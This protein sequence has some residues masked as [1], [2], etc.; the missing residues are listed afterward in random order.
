MIALA[1]PGEELDKLN[2]EENIR[3][4]GVFM[5][6]E[7]SPFTDLRSLI[8]LIRVF[9]REQPRM[10]H[11]M[12]PKA[13]LLSMLA[14]KMCG[15][16]VRLHSFTGLLFPTASGVKKKLFATCDKI[17]CGCATHIVA[18]G[19]GVRKDLLDSSITKKRID[20]LGNGNVRGI[21]LDYYQR[22]PEVM[23][24]AAEIR[25]NIGADADTFIFIFVGRLV[26]DKGIDNLVEAFLNLSKE[27]D[28]LRLLL[29]GE[30]EN[31]DRVKPS[32]I[33]AIEESPLI[34]KTGWKEDVR[35]FYAASDLLV[36]PSRREGFPNVVIEAGAMG[37]PSV[38]T[39]INGSNE[40]ISDGVNGRIIPK[41]DLQPLADEMK[42]LSENREAAAA[43][44]KDARRIVSERYERSFVLN[45]LENYYREILK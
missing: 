30:Y 35:P 27:K 22:T 41:D 1:S 10:V 18:E 14:A 4:L 38:V 37:L 45:K 28:N 5:S 26:K 15:V 12:T 39:D 32:T 25:R 9:R 43:L 20:I 11:S 6:R 21:D 40:I 17:I 8:K 13:G 31:G 44:A 33:Q 7:I 36:F 29:V 34:I 24:K 2:R 19:R 23:E 42:N 16:P 3:T